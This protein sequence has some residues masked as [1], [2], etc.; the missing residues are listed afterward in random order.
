L[1]EALRGLPL[2]RDY[3]LRFRQAMGVGRL[4]RVFLLLQGATALEAGVWLVLAELLRQVSAPRPLVLA[5]VLPP[6]ALF[7]GLT[8][9]RILAQRAREISLMRL[10]LDYLNILRNRLYATIT[11][12]PWTSIVG[13]RHSSVVSVLTSD[14]DR[15][16]AGT[17]ALLQGM[18][19][20]GVGLVTLGVAIYVSPALALPALLAGAVLS[21]LLLGQT[22]RTLNLG[23]RLTEAHR[24]F[25]SNATDFLS[26]LKLVKAQGGEASLLQRFERAGRSLDSEQIAFT[27]YQTFRRSLLELGGLV[28]VAALLLYATVGLQM[29]LP[30]LL[31]ALYLLS[32]LVPLVNQGAT[33]AQMVTH[34]L[35]AWAA[36]RT[37]ERGLANAPQT[38]VVL[39]H[40][41][42]ALVLR[43]GVA[44]HN[45]VLRHPGSDRAALQGVSLQIPA[46]ATVALVGP[47]GAG[48]TSIA[49]M[50]LG[51]LRPDSGHLSIDGVPFDDSLRKP[52]QKAIAY[53]PQETLLLPTT[54]RNNLVWDSA[55]HDE[56]ALWQALELALADG[57]V[58]RLPQGLD[59]VLGEQG[60]GLSGGE[61]QRLTLARA[62]L[63]QPQLLV[64]DE[65]TS[66]LDAENEQLIRRALRQV[67]GRMT[68]LLIAHRL[69]TV[70]EADEIVLLDEGR[71]L[72]TGS[73]DAL[74][75]AQPVF[76]A[77][78]LAGG[79]VPI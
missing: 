43:Q 48:K 52:W 32:R 39:P 38:A 63:R 14:L 60:A 36:L 74:M 68:I 72:G 40:N 47:S 54:V 6:L 8:V 35:P 61:R 31:L 65:A 78:V 19:T 33:Y 44:L 28:L 75:A 20:V 53:V 37:L 24:A 7:C 23:T 49:D 17:L 2:L 41:T 58:R 12:A 67:A 50:V 11:S 73:W 55:S 21:L 71:V 1:P 45:V 13:I 27:R 10:R 77:L 5:A 51:L 29:A 18:V 25:V 15:I 62:F 3:L 76:R 79:N 46:Y 30:S 57:F 4:V 34:M 64:L 26:V 66:H 70:R 16:N 59:T 69:S 56:A 22:R 42:S 9:A